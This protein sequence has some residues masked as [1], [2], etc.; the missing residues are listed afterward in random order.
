MLPARSS[1]N[2]PDSKSRFVLLRV[3]P[4]VVK[5]VERLTAAAPPM[6][7]FFGSKEEA[8]F[9]DRKP[10]AVVM[11]MGIPVPPSRSSDWATQRSLL[12]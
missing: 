9:Y 12:S 1:L 5:A 2:L 4:A 7:R 3:Q 6:L 11:L 8:S 10:S